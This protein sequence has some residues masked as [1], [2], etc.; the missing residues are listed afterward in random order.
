MRACG[1]CG[2]ADGGALTID[3][4]R[5][6]AF[7]GNGHTERSNAGLL[8]IPMVEVM[9][10]IG[11][12]DNIG[13][14]YEMPAGVLKSGRAGFVSQSGAFGTFI[15]TLAAENGVEPPRLSPAA[16]AAPWATRWTASP[17]WPPPAS[18]RNPAG[19]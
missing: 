14:A 9:G 8:F 12:D 4:L 17:A 16:A 18:A 6:R 5:A 13:Q 2:R 1:Q 19:R 15:F 10:S 7:G 3:D 11:M